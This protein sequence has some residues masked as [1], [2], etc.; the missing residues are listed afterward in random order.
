M[1]KVIGTIDVN[2]SNQGTVFLFT[3]NTQ[4][5]KDWVKEHLQLASWQWTGNRSFAVDHHY[6]ENLC[7]GM[8]GDGLVVR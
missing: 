8:R 1:A 6:A 5:A 3:L 7:H 2:V 4:A